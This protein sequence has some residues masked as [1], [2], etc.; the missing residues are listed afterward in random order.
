MTDTSHLAGPSTSLFGGS[1]GIARIEITPPAGIYARNW[2]AAAHD[3]ALSIHRPLSI[4]AMTIRTDGEPPLVLTDADLG[5][6]T[7]LDRFRTMRAN[8]LEGLRLDSSRFIFAMTHT[9]A[10]PHLCDP[11]PGMAGGDLLEEWLATLEP[12]TIR[13]IRDAFANERESTLDWNYGRCRLATTRDLPDPTRNGERRICGYDPATPADDTLLVGRVC[14]L[15]GDLRATIVNYACHPTTL[16]WSNTA[17]SPDYIGAMREA[18][19][20]HTKN[21]PAFFLQGASGELS[22]RYQYVGD[23][24]VADRH[25]RQLG[26]AALAAFEDMEPPGTRLAFD[27][28]VES[29]AP[30]AVWTPRPIEPSRRLAAVEGSVS[31]P[32]KADLPSA[33]ELDRAYQ[34]C[35]DRALAERLRR[36][37]N[38][39]RVLGDED[40]FALPIWTWRIGDAIV[41][42]CMGEAY[43]V[44]QTTLRERFPEHHLVCMNLINGT[45]GYLPPAETYDLDLYQ[46]WQSPFARGCLERYLEAAD[47]QIRSLIETDDL[48]RANA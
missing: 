43:S 14:D 23:P 32:I 39:R 1:I 21:A 28:V 42:G 48:R 13:A 45:I 9:H 12:A 15:A 46:V 7:S 16:A 37:R 47:A 11:Q 6:W 5:F 38:L 22:P 10:S 18:I 40:S 35:A 2:G 19:E 4:S 8:I 3:V 17:V 33:E 44:V 36:K 26:F 20:T 31:I 30:L 41:V 24:A 29:G 27:G 25:G 34:S